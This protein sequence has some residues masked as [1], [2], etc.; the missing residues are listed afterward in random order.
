MCNLCVLLIL[1]LTN[2][3]ISVTKC[4]LH[5]WFYIKITDVN[6]SVFVYRLFREVLMLILY[7]SLW[8]FLWFCWRQVVC[9][10][11]FLAAAADPLALLHMGALLC[12]LSYLF[13]N[14]IIGQGQYKLYKYLGQRFLTSQHK[15][16]KRISL[17]ICNLSLSIILLKYQC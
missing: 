3:Y 4:M 15:T 1:Y 9:K 13:V 8:S 14:G 2:I 17:V 11:C 7:M 6:L 5:C 16:R 12:C 10:Y